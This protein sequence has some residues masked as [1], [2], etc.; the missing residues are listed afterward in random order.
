MPKLTAAQ[1]AQ[2]RAHILDAA[3]VCFARSGFHR[4]TMQD[5]CRLAGVSA[6]AVYVYFA[7]KE[8]LID[9]IVDRDRDEVTRELQRVGEAPD[10]MTGLEGLLRSCILERPPHKTALYLEMLSEANRNPHV[11]AA[12]QGCETGLHRALA[13]MLR[14]SQK[15]GRVA[16]DI[17][18]EIT[19]RMLMVVG[20]GLFVLMARRAT[21]CV[22]EVVPNVLAMIGLYLVATGAPAPAR[23]PVPSAL[24]ARPAVAAA[25]LD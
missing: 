24:Y 20:D 23:P 22:A 13:E 21:D 3:E 16:P 15:A 18:P 10:L 14:D 11:S 12:V 4:T 6:G 19:A 7:S 17:D 9:G 8:A 5:M 25:A 1:Q 2:R